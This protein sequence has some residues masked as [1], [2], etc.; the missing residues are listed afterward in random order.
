MLK[1]TVKKKKKDIEKWY[2]V[3]YHNEKAWIKKK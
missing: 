2:S 1:T 3:H